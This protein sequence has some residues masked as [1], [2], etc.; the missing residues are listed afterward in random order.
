L[1][2]R[3]LMPY[4]RQLGRNFC[5][6]SLLVLQQLVLQIHKQENRFMRFGRI[7]YLYS[8][9]IV[10]VAGAHYSSA[11]ALQKLS[12]AVCIPVNC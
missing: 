12:G 7:P 10:C 4:Q 9:S 1:G 6:V 3:N 8:N 5:V 2:R 11:F